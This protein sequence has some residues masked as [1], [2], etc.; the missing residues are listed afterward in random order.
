MNLPFFPHGK[1]QFGRASRD[2]SQAMNFAFFHSF[3]Q[4]LL[5]RTI[6]GNRYLFYVYDVDFINHLELGSL[7]S[8]SLL[9]FTL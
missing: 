8:N 5:I 2:I 7:F 6:F 9:I 1:P 4:C 3:V